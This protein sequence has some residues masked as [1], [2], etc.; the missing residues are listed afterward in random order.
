MGWVGGPAGSIKR[1]SVS[2][3]HFVTEGFKLLRGQLLWDWKLHFFLWKCESLIFPYWDKP[4]LSQPDVYSECKKSARTR[5]S[6]C[7]CNEESR[8]RTPQEVTQTWALWRDKWG[9]G[10]VLHEAVSFT[11]R[12][13]HPQTHNPASHHPHCC[14]TQQFAHCFS[15]S[16]TRK[17]E[18][19]SGSM[20]AVLELHPSSPMCSPLP[21]LPLQS[22]LQ[23][24]KG[25][26][27]LFLRR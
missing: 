1:W 16:S 3:K 19:Q 20:G 12:D 17:A 18:F 4:Q 2:V 8:G 23:H 11:A 25:C 24:L 10:L 26:L 15:C 22:S 21:L 27:A 5:S 9:Q 7:S 6:V 14:S 13:K